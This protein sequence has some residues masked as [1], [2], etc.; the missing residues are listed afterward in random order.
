MCISI[1]GKW[2]T[3]VTD[4]GVDRSGQGC[5]S[6]ITLSSRNSTD[7][8]FIFAYR[9]CQM[10]GTKVGLLTSYTQQ[11]MMSRV[12]GNAQPDP[13][14]DL[15]TDLEQFVKEQ[16]NN[17]TLAVSIFIDANKMLGDEA[18][19]LQRLTASLNLTDAYDTLLGD[20]SPASY[21]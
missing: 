13:R 8:M 15:I 7:V 17:R 11:L 14:N 20:E 6:Y 4:R 2:A 1:I 3:R 21:L 9:V 16:C 19:G 12:A 5:W 18:N 10:Q